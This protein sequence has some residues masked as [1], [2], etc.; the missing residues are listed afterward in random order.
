MTIDC[1]QRGGAPPTVIEACRT[2]LPSLPIT[3]IA[4]RFS[5][6]FAVIFDKSPGDGRTVPSATIVPSPGDLPETEDDPTAEA[7][8]YWQKR[9][10]TSTT[11]ILGCP[12]L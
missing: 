8:G 3:Q 11:R 9:N 2:Y 4:H 7:V 10:E 12:G 5:G 1:C 6:G